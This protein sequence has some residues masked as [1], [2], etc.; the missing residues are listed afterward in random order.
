M[1][2]CCWLLEGDLGMLPRARMSGP[3]VQR[4]HFIYG[5]S[6]A[7]RH[8]RLASVCL[9]ALQ[10]AAARD[11]SNSAGLF[12]EVPP[13]PWATKPPHPAG[14][15]APP[16]PPHRTSRPPRRRAPS[17]AAP[18]APSAAAPPAALRLW[19]LGLGQ[20]MP[21][22]LWIPGALHILH[23][24]CGNLTKEP[25]PHAPLPPPPPA[26]LDDCECY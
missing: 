10:D 20:L 9:Q 3:L 1:L 19:Q 4:A 26:P 7:F 18:P 15:A 23:G 21:I 6:R 12:F 5:L 14:K 22:C 17:A 11:A 25:G 16:P 13:R 2:P 8:H 24:A